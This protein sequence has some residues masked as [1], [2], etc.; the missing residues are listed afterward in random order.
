MLGAGALVSLLGW[1]REHR[2]E[3]RERWAVRTGLAML[4]LALIYAAGHARLLAQRESIQQGREAYARYGDPRLA[5][6][7]RAEVRGWLLDCT[8]DDERALAGY[9][10][11]DGSIERSYPL[12]EAGANLIGSAG[13]E[14]DFTIEALFAEQLRRPRSWFERGQLHPAGR[15]VQLTLCSG[16]TRVAWRLLSEA[17]RPGAV[18]AQDVRT[19]ALIAY[20]ATGTANDAPLGI[21]QYA[22]PGSVFKL[23]LAALWWESGMP[24]ETPLECPSSIEVT[25]RA[26]ISNSGNAAYGT[27]AAPREVLVFSCNTAAV[28]MAQR[29][30]EELGSDAFVDAYGRFGFTPYASKSPSG[31]EQEFWATGSDRWRERMSPPPARIRISDETG[32]AEWAQLSIGQGPVDVTPLHISRF[33]QAIGNDG[34][35]LPPTF[36]QRLAAKPPRGERVM[37]EETAARLQAAMLE[38]VDRG[39]ARRVS[40]RLRGTGWNLGGKTGTAQVR[41]ARDDGWF[42]G[43]IFDEQGEP[44]YT[45]AAYLRGGGPGGSGPATIAAGLAHYLATREPAEG[46]T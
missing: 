39:T 12:G 3:R 46:A 14:R 37:S 34:V 17:G 24:D 31:T 28:Q 25:P 5:E 33:L 41:G 36:E 44:A 26:T 35:M 40:P 16:A 45:V 20:A 22:P 43:L 2:S 23:A 13:G 15:D 10:T 21:K 27:L 7:R 29:M 9:Q 8:G 11:V 4:L 1:V 18:V 30:R 32:K 19:G 42:A 38:V 6:R